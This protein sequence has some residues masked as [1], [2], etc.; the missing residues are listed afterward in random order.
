MVEILL[1]G[2]QRRNWTKADPQGIS[3][4]SQDEID[5]FCQTWLF[6]GCLITHFRSVS[7]QVETKDFDHIE[8]DEAICIAT[9]LGL[10]PERPLRIIKE[11]AGEEAPR[12]FLG[13]RLSDEIVPQP[14]DFDDGLLVRKDALFV[15]GHGLLVQFPAYLLVMGGS[16]AAESMVISDGKKRFDVPLHMDEAS[17]R[18][19]VD[20]HTPDP[21]PRHKI[22]WK[23][24][25]YIV[26][27]EKYLLVT[28]CLGGSEATFC[29]MHT[30]IG[31]PEFMWPTHELR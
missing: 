27:N 2:P 19:I 10:S 24:K 29:A 9:L 22:K 16:Q 1:K 26:S 4:R 6:S 5:A 3:N 20:H 30:I 13:Q 25:D 21:A 11:S 7:I 17:L 15:S 12:T 8:Q 18:Q 23:N 31:E 28:Y 14:A